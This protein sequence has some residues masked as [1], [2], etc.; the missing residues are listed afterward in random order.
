MKKLIKKMIIWIIEKLNLPHLLSQV[1]QKQNLRNIEYNITNYGATF[2][3]EA[4]VSN[5]QDRSKITVGKGSHIRG[6][7]LVFKYGGKIIIGENCHIGDHSRIWSGESV[8]IGNFV[9]I[10]HNVN[11]MDTNAHELDAIE[12]A[13]RWMDL[14]QNGAWKDKGNVITAPVVIGDYT[15]ICLNATILRGV[16]IGKGAIIAAGSVVTKDVPE[17][18]LVAGNPAKV[19]KTL[20]KK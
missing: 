3:P 1:Q 6:I 12:R 7:L 15:W 14:L 9:Q 8:T 5:G 11:I 10:S 19:V 4:T 18:T 2:Y 20:Q 16:N 13:E 17:Y